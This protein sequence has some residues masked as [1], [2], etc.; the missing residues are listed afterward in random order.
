MRVNIRRRNKKTDYT[1]T[2]NST[3][4]QSRQ[5]AKEEHK[6]TCALTKKN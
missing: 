5:A 2:M 1:F 6:T 4:K 3:R